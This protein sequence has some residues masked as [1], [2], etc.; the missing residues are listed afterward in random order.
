MYV[1]QYQTRVSEKKPTSCEFEPSEAFKNRIY[2]EFKNTAR[3]F[4]GLRLNTAATFAKFPLI[5]HVLNYELR[6]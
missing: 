2:I 6:R 5:T 3:E 4:Y 1:F